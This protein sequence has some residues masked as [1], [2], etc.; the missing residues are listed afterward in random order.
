[1]VGLLIFAVI[2]GTL[3][4]EF[5]MVVVGLQFLLIIF[6]WIHL[7]LGLTTDTILPTSW[8]TYFL[9]CDVY[10]GPGAAWWAAI[11]GAVICLYS[12]VVLLFPYLMGPLWVNHV[13]NSSTIS[14]SF[15]LSF[16]DE[17]HDEEDP[18]HG[19]EFNL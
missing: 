16:P 17:A 7:V 14:P 9:G 19:V 18:Y 13:S 8:K 6:I 5:Q 12:S 3:T 4:W 11:L 10:T 1:M 15:D 2:D